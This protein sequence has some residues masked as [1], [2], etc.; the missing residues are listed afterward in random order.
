[1]IASVMSVFVSGQSSPCVLRCLMLQKHAS[2]VWQWRSECFSI[3]HQM[4]EGEQC[5]GC[6]CSSTNS[7]ILQM[8]HMWKISVV[9]GTETEVIF[10][11]VLT[12]LCRLL[13]STLVQF[14]YQIVKKLLRFAGCLLALLARL[15]LLALACSLCMLM[16][17]NTVMYIW[18]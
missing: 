5:R 3:S 6:V 1:M 15:A 8:Q 11:V 9:E 12:I 10:S 7:V 14:P 18:W 2:A 16:R 17:P 13:Q 4:A